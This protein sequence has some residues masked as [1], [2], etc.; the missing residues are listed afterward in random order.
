M[1]CEVYVSF[2]HPNFINNGER[3][4]IEIHPS[5]RIDPAVKI[6]LEGNDHILRIAENTVIRNMNILFSGAFNVVEIG[7]GCNLRG[8]LHIRQAE[9]RLQIGAGTTFVGAHLFAM[10]GKSIVIGEDCMFSSGIY[11]RT[12]DE[13]PIYDLSGGERLNGPQDV[14]LGRHV[15]IGEGTTLGKGT[16]IPEGCVIG[17]RSYVS[18][19]LTRPHSIYAGAPARLMRENVVWD[20]RLKKTPLEP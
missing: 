18:K 1:H 17:A 5:A 20:R 10:E 15:W 2:E 14:I 16:N 6:H 9:S 8:A 7:V 13:H 3:N 11:V 4:V 19:R 12:S